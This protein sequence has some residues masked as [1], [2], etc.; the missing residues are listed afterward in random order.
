MSLFLVFLILPKIYVEFYVILETIV[1]IWSYLF[2]KN[3][4]SRDHPIWV[5]ISDFGFIT[6]ILKR[7]V[8]S[9]RKI[10]LIHIVT[11]TVFIFAMID[12][13]SEGVKTRL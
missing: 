13:P 2:R 1:W 11:V 9:G 6:C 8:R 7:I 10:F 12:F 4:E 5:G 3:D